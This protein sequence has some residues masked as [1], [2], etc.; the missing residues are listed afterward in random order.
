MA[1]R[2][3]DSLTWMDAR[4][5]GVPVTP[6]VGCPVELS[7]LWAKGCE[8]LGRLARAAGDV[9]LSERA[10]AASKRARV[11]FRLRFWCD[12]TQYPFDVIGEATEGEGALRDRA[13]RPNAVIA[14]AVDPECFTPERAAMVLDRAHQELVTRAGLRSISPADPAYVAHYGGGVAARDQA[15]HQG[16]V[17]PYLLGFFVRAAIRSIDGEHLKPLLLRLVASAASNE[18]ALG[19]VPEVA[20]GETP[21]APNG[22]FAQAW[23]VAELLRAAAWDLGG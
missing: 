1:G 4:V 22:C 13:V 19:Q 2:D 11:A 18:L 16:T 23:S 6:R 12:E 14:L 5:G 8:T 10:F 7:A 21:H 20:D 15:Y 3:G 17:W 9:P